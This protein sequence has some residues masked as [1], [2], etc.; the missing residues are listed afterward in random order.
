MKL[1]LQIP[2]YNEAQTL[3]DTLRLLPRAIPG[4]DQVEV[5]V[6]DDFSLW[7][8]IFGMC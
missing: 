5:L 8:P 7:C 2:C 6:I 1:I 3:A 4:V